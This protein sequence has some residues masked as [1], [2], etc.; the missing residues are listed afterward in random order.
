MKGL[1]SLVSSCWGDDGGRGGMTAA[2]PLVGVVGLGA[3]GAATAY[4]L[5]RRGARVVGLEAFG[6]GHDRGS[7]HGESR[8]I[9]QAYYSDPAYVPLVLRAYELWR[10]LEAECREPILRITGGLILG[11]PDSGLV[12]GALASSRKYGLEARLLTASEVRREFPALDP[13][14]GVTAL[15][16]PGAGVLRPEAGV[17]CHLRAAAEA[18]A[19]LRFG[20]PALAW[21]PTADAVMVE[22]P[23]GQL[24]F[25]HLV[26]TAGAW[27]SKLL[28][29]WQLPLTVERQVMVW[30]R[31]AVAEPFA[32]DLLPA[33]Y[34][35]HDPGHSWYGFPTL[36]GVTVKVA[37]HHGGEVTT[38]ESVDRECHQEELA[39]IREGIGDVAPSLRAAPV[40]HARVGLMTN[41]PD[42]DFALGPH[43]EC[44]RVQVACGFSGHGYK[45]SPVIGE[46]MADLVLE[47]RSRRPIG[48]LEASRLVEVSG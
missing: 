27:T 21:A 47:G 30:L 1:D 9:H 16:E 7:S 48:P 29:G 17:L 25:D 18:G 22:T 43:P 12:R 13:P 11:A 34:Y 33:F 42:G 2:R 26:L 39:A 36:D 37:R 44:P 23:S 14:R 31:P 4:H 32:P 46:L 38:P 15:L 10:E 20:E 40:V 24:R 41:T 6:P 5:A 19:S 3:M 35:Q 28:R 45:F 8:V